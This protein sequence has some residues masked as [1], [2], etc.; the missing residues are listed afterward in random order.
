MS[1]AVRSSD[2]HPIPDTVERFRQEF[3]ELFRARFPLIYVV[4]SEEERLEKEL[5]HVL[6]DLDLAGTVDL[7]T[8]SI[9]GGLS[10]TDAI[11]SY[12]T[13]IAG[14]AD[15]STLLK[16]IEDS[17]QQSLF[18]VKDFQWFL[19]AHGQAPSP[20]LIR[21]LL[22]LASRMKHG[23]VRRAVVLQA[24][25][26]ELPAELEKAVAVLTLPLPS[27]AEIRTTLE[28]IIIDNAQSPQVTIDLDSEAE[29]DAMAHA[30]TGMTLDEAENAFARAI[31]NDFVLDHHD[32][33]VVHKEKC[34]AIR[35][36]QLLEVVEPRGDLNVVGGLG[37]L[38]AWLLK[39][40]KSWLGEAKDYGLECPRGL[41]ITGV[42]GCGKSLAATC[43]AEQWELPL[44]RLDVG[45]IF[46]GLI[47][48]SEQN[49]RRALS[50]AEAVSPCVL[51]IDE[52]E[53]GFG[54]S[55]DRDGGTARRVFG[56]F[57]TWLQEKTSPVFVIATANQIEALPP[58][59]LRK[60][61]FDETFFVDLPTEHERRRIFEIH[62]NERLRYP[63]AAGLLRVDEAVLSS[64]ATAAS[65]YSGAE[66]EQSIVAGLFDAYQE[67]RGLELN[68]VLSG[69]RQT[70]PLSQ[71]MREEILSIRE[72]A[73]SRAVSA[74][75]EHDRDHSQIDGDADEL[76][77]V[78]GGRLI[79]F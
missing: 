72:W 47:G 11:G 40:D 35:R 17:T 66:I 56:S 21:Q 3:T 6:A 79:D 70:V 73:D 77:S 76:L 15:A 75:S 38:K 58:E 71:T 13:P 1:D 7:Q 36:G 34:Q 25:S 37:N 5:R 18:L 46:Q 68:D 19:G 41:L 9:A 49:M 29:R 51:W 42:P 28:Q 39:R 8:W 59:F 16:Q 54:G 64:L 74:T 60:G 50:L 45:R 48:S 55:G 53:K 31:A 65:G 2:R 61:R 22:D 32:I 20:F 23:P 12:R 27:V 33:A 10:S 62:L 24:P 78:R 14:E 44:L 52:I 43:V 67:R 69:I 4:T 30:A 57:L 63:G 26:L